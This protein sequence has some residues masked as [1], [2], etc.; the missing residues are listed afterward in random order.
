[1]KRSF[2]QCDDGSVCC[3]SS[4]SGG[5]NQA[6]LIQG[7]ITPSHDEEL[8]AASKRINQIL[9]EIKANNRDPKRELALLSIPAEDDGT[10]LLLAWVRSGV[11]VDSSVEDFKKVLGAF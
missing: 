7:I 11:S 8:D 5:C 4:N 9:D 1:M 3:F 6:R 2:C 10:V